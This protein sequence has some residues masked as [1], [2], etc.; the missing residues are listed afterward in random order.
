MGGLMARI[1]R[2]LSRTLRYVLYAAI[3]VLLL[4]VVAV[5]YLTL[6]GPGRSTLSG[7]VS[8]LA[9]SPQQ[10]VEVSDISGIWSGALRVGAVEVSDS[11][12]TW[13]ALTGVAVDWSPLD[14]ASRRFT[15][16]RVHADKVDVRR[17]PLPAPAEPQEPGAGFSLPVAIDIARLD[18]PDIALGAGLA[19]EVARL[20]AGGKLM[21][22]RSPIS[23]D[24]VLDID[25]TDGRA[26]S[27][28]ATIA[29]LPQDNRITLDVK[30]SEPAGG[31]I[32]GL[33]QLPGDPAVEL[34]VSGSGPAAD[35]KGQGSFSI[36]G[37]QI[38]QLEGRHRMNDAG[39]SVELTGS[40]AF[41]RFL[42]EIARP[43]LAGQSAFDIAVSM[44]N[45]GGIRV[46][47]GR[48][49]SDALGVEA[50]GTIDAA[51]SND[52]TLQARA[53]RS[54]VSLALGDEGAQTVVLVDRAD[55]RVLG[56]E[57][58]RIEANVGLPSLQ[59][60]IVTAA[61]LDVSLQSE[62]FDL[63]SQSGP[64]S[65]TVN[66]AS[67]TS[68]NASLGPLLEGATSVSATG[69]LDADSITISDARIVNEV[70]SIGAQGQ[71]SRLD[72]SLG[73]DIVADV[74]A[75][76][77][78]AAAQA[79]LGERVQLAGRVER[80]AEGA[81]D[82]SGFDL[83]SGGLTLAGSV[84]LQG[85]SID[86]DLSGTLADLAALSPQASGAISFSTK[87]SGELAA[88]QFQLS[89]SGERIES[90]GRAITDFDLEASGV[91]DPA[92]PSAELSLSGSV[93]G[94]A[95]RGTAALG[96]GETQR[97][98]D[99][100]DI[101]LGD[102]RITGDVQLDENFLP[103]GTLKVSIP[104][105]GPLAA[106]ALEEIAGSLSADLE[107]TREGETPVLTVKANV[108]QF[109]RQ[110]ISARDIAID[111]RITNY[112]AAP[113]ISGKVTAG[114]IN[115]GATMVEG[116][117]LA[118]GT[119][120]PWTAFNLSARF[121]GNPASASGG[122]MMQEGLVTVELDNAEG[123]YQ[124]TKATL[125]APTSIVVREGTAQFN[126]LTLTVNGGRIAVS[127]SAGETLNINANVS[128][129]PLSTVN[130]FA[131]GLDAAGTAN[132]SISVTG[133]ADNPGIRYSAD[134]SGLAVAQTRSAGLGAMT[135]SSSGTFSGGRLQFNATAS[136]GSGF[137]LNGGGSVAT[138][139]NR[140]LG[141]R[142]SGRVPFNFLS[143]Q[144]AAQGLSLT[145]S[146][147][148]NISVGG[149][150]GAPAISGSISSSG[151]RFVDA[152]S[153]LAVTDIATQ[154]NIANNV[155]S[156]QSLNGTL[157]T[158]GRLSASGTVGID[159]AQ[160]FPADLDIRLD[161]GR[162]VDG[163][164]V[165]ASLDGALEINGP[166]V[167]AA[168]IRGTINL[169]RTVVT[170]PE[171]LPGS[172]NALNVQHKNAP[173]AVVEQQRAI[174]P[175]TGGGGESGGLMLDIT[176]NAPQQIFVRGRGLDAE[177][178]GSLRLTGPSSS[179][180]AT[181]SFDLRRGRLTV[182]AKRLAF[183]RGTITFSGSLTPY[184]D[185]AADS[186]AGTTNV[187]VLVRGPA[188]DPEFTFESSPAMPQDEVLAQLVFGRTI[189][190]LSPVQIA[191]LA[192]AAAQL[193]GL[194]GPGN[195]LDT[196]RARTGLDDIDVRTDEATG[197]SSVAAGK[198][199]NDRTYVTIERGAEAGSGKAAIDLEIGRGIKLRGEA[200]ED[201]ET[202]GGIFFEREY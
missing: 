79:P 80:T 192:A 4:A 151:A 147:N 20:S 50:S 196:L 71:V 124:A 16:S 132:A 156:I 49:D 63:A 3:V 64:F 25:R 2:V 52:F 172:L 41:A 105:L 185:M 39:R 106:L 98:L 29:Y 149:T 100:L 13:L 110:A 62:A 54:P 59:T 114:R 193:A 97:S 159:A 92:Q 103:L 18:F 43:A 178:G 91:A 201:G 30:G 24:T 187:T 31:I 128:G 161:E 83:K 36:D 76:A 1:L 170:I 90:A 46:E 134:L 127:G 22:G 40:G 186:Q 168:T 155:A 129:L 115:S 67:L 61:D 175:S 87:A 8:D 85:T 195:L 162:Y 113:A 69:A 75:S 66:A 93:E 144:L 117:N 154:V 189:D 145:G 47:R 34:A 116:V 109:S 94:E 188:T 10:G 200:H 191:Q 121:D 77:L 48:I 26:G 139:G 119:D 143:A 12:G 86:A 38:A 126:G 65:L 23:I 96:G 174:R 130:A 181:G 73:F 70:A 184:L 179:P 35:W 125:A 89:L 108:P 157:S 133:A 153:G 158:G 5:G 95:L 197:E 180:Q 37:Q 58:P 166:L 57:S 42:P 74:L 177:L 104:D 81:I 28:D 183:T 21:A 173:R 182:L 190:D 44:P 202:K 118:L 160:G 101:T 111:A 136:E 9:S 56:A 140:A 169:G 198:Y 55:I 45:T 82:V 53:K 112:V 32:A 123:A 107:F 152:R 142:F 19:G 146:A 84:A 14:L 135:V 120:G 27:I 99:A 72:G 137:S 150:I 171:R 6:T 11:D 141:L 51:G 15:A 131:P 148:A 60:G 199:L 138:Q 164:L 88:P 176:V 7:I 68:G 102:S 165:T 167:S 163:R 17:Q 122:V 33:L 194:S 78:P